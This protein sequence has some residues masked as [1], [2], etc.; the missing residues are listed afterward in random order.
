M[1]S[2][3]CSDTMFICPLPVI[4]LFVPRLCPASESRHHLGTHA[5]RFST[6]TR[7]LPRQWLPK[8]IRAAISGKLHVTVWMYGC[9]FS[10]KHPRDTTVHDYDFPPRTKSEPVKIVRHGFAVSNLSRHEWVR[11]VGVLGK[12][13]HNTARRV[14]SIAPLRTGADT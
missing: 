10:Q 12:K 7:S 4:L 1:C 6:D 11:Q 8:T 5:W 2:W 13:I 3:S 9:A 14:S